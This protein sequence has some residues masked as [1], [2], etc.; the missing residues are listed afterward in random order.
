[1]DTAL[2]ALF[3]SY[4]LSATYMT[5]DEL[6]GDTESPTGVFA[7]ITIGESDIDGIL[8]ECEDVTSAYGV[9]DRGDI[10]G[11]FL[12][13]LSDQGIISIHQYATRDAL[14]KDYTALAEEY[15][16]WLDS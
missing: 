7:R 9:P 16:G 11:H 13:R 2:E 4:V 14:D 8:A 5:D 1:M 6:D 15:S 12:V 3:R 10:V